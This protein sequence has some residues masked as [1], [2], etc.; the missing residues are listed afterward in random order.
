MTGD[1]PEANPPL[2]KNK[3]IL[4]WQ[5]GQLLGLSPDMMT[6]R[7]TARMLEPDRWEQ[8]AHSH[9]VVWGL[10]KRPKMEP[11][12]IA[13]KKS[14]LRATCTCSASKQPCKFV[15]ALYMLFADQPHLFQVLQEPAWIQFQFKQQTH[16]HKQNVTIDQVKLGM[17]EYGRWLRDQIRFGVSNFADR[18]P[19][20]LD[21][22]ANLL[23]DAHLP[24]MADEL[25]QL[26]RMVAPKKGAPPANWPE[27]LVQKLGRF[28]M[29]VQAWENFAQLSYTQQQDLIHT[30]VSPQV[31]YVLA[32]PIYSDAYVDANIQWQI[33]GR[34][35]VQVGRNW[36]RRTW[37]HNGGSGRFLLLEDTINGRDHSIPQFVTDSVYTHEQLF[38]PPVTHASRLFAP[39]VPEE[40]AA[41]FPAIEKKFIQIRVQNPW[42]TYYPV[43]LKQVRLQFDENGRYWLLVDQDGCAIPMT[44]GGDLGW[45]LVASSKGGSLD[46]FAEWTVQGVTLLSVW[47]NGCWTDLSVW[48]SKA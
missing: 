36:S 37:G 35:F 9:N 32:D 15:M 46:L 29:Q 34:Y 21:A 48:G 20:E 39:M 12:T 4:P 6:V 45:H 25:R 22:M 17:A 19:T 26:G 27:I 41:D 14:D 2:V 33:V 11:H 8:L 30:C 38:V 31:K 13:F 1:I 42:Q 10:Y 5:G 18:V 40:I 24:Q 23:I 7:G 43:L 28:Y 44:N 47:V 16:P 3:K